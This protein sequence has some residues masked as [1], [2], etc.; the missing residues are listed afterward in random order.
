[1]ATDTGQTDQTFGKGDAQLAG[2]AHP[3]L[4]SE[5]TVQGVTVRPEY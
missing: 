3:A 4:D 2:A 1:M 5:F